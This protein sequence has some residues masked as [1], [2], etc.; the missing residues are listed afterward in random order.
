MIVFLVCVFNQW[1]EATLTIS[2]FTMIGVLTPIIAVL[3]WKPSIRS[4]DGRSEPSLR[5]ETMNRRPNK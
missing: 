5:R 1:I 4:K 2:A 3:I